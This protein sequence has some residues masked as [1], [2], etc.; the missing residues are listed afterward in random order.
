MAERPSVPR[1]LLGIE[2]LSAEQLVPFLDLAE[3]YALLS[4]SRS[5]PRD[6]LRGRTVINLFYEDSKIGRASCRER[7]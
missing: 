3:S 4:R 5:A 2:G 6:A 7:V 1:H